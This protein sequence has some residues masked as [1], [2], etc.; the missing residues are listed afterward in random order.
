MGDTYIRISSARNPRTYPTW[1]KPNFEPNVLGI[2][3]VCST[4]YYELCLMHDDR[5]Q[6]KTTNSFDRQ[7]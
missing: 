5:V 1:F 2:Y 3:I 4:S 6:T 7:Q